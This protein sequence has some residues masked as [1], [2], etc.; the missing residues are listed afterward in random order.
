MSEHLKARAVAAPWWGGIEVLLFQSYGGRQY[1]SV[2]TDFVKTEDLEHAR[3]IDPSF[4]LDREDAQRLID[5]LWECGLRP[6]SGAGSAGQLSATQA[7]LEDMRRL[8]FAGKGE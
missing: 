7:H 6:S 3:V 8:V 5:D 1:A 2:V 4:V